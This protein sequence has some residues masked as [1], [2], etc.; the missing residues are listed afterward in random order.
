MRKNF[1]SH[2]V[3]PIGL[4][5]Y[6]CIMA[7]MGR[8]NLNNPTQRTTYLISIGVELIILVGLYFFLKKRNELRARRNEELSA[9]KTAGKKK[10]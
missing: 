5:I 6:A 9:S 2:I 3:I 1:K 7:W 4:F 10:P 8:A